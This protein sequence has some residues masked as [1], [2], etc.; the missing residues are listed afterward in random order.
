MRTLFIVFLLS[1]IFS[2]CSIKSDSS[3]NCSASEPNYLKLPSNAIKAFPLL[4]EREGKTISFSDSEIFVDNSVV[5]LEEF[6]SFNV[7]KSNSSYFI[8]FVFNNKNCFFSVDNPEDFSF[9]KN[10]LLLDI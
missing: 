4:V 2:G 10:K 9:I 3:Y 8:H 6:S 1:L 7:I 5:K